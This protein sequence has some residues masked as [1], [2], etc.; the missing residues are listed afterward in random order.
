MPFVWLYR[1]IGSGFDSDIP[2]FEV[3][4]GNGLYFIHLRTGDRELMFSDRSLGDEDVDVWI[5]D[6]GASFPARN[7]C[8][9]V[10]TVLSI[11]KRYFDN[12]DALEGI[13]W[14]DY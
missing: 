8:R 10:D 9:D 1:N 11:A 13:P 12:G 5:N 7:V 6:Q 4:G 14:E 3:T 2:D